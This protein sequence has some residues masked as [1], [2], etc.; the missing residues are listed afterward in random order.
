MES[1]AVRYAVLG[2]GS[3]ANS[4]IIENSSGSVLVDQGFT[5]PE[6][7][8]RAEKAAFNI[9]KLKYIFLTHDHSDHSRGVASLAAYLNIP[10]IMHKKAVIRAAGA[11]GYKRWN[12]EG[13]KYYSDEELSLNFTAFPTSH[14]APFSMGF[15]I[16]MS[17]FRFTFITDTGSI[18]P[19]MREFA[20]T[21]HVL[22]LESN[23]SPDMLQNG[24]YPPFLKARVSGE[25][26]HLS[27]YAAAGFLQSLNTNRRRRVFLCHLSEN[28][29]SPEQL[30]AEFSGI[31][32]LTAAITVCPRSE[33]M[34]SEE[35]HIAAAE[36]FYFH[37]TSN[38]EFFD[39]ASGRK[40]LLL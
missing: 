22:F 6:L 25:R 3:S 12:I 37:C 11:A 34:P 8:Y 5:L 10:V 35:L 7:L 21:T 40:L 33:L 32:P 19:L 2:S 20:D 17:G 1:R 28:N 26:G 39:T 4:Y 30:R 31:M 16:E 24:P 18:T 36:P 29:N 14:D 15:F 23:Y 27:N 13:Y 9:Y 38:R